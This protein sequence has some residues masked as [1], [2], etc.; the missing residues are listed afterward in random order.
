LHVE[1]KKLALSN[2]VNLHL[3]CKVV[4]VDTEIARIELQ[5]G[6]VFEGDLLIA[7]DGIHSLVRKACIGEEREECGSKA[8]AGNMYRWL[9]D[10]EAVRSDGLTRG[11]LR[12]GARCLYALP[13]KEEK[14]WLA[15]YAC[16]E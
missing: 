6:Q 14:V 15:G 4:S 12:E 5:D 9:L 3:A 16:R 7:A 13:Y 8:I 10:T 11:L 1:L 2:G